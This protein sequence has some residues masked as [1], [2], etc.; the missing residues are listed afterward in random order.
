MFAQLFNFLRVKLNRSEYNF[1]LILGSLQIPWTT[2]Q[3]DFNFLPLREAVEWT[4]PNDGQ[5][6]LQLRLFRSE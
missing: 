6:G 5:I 2:K 4:V 3:F 1:L